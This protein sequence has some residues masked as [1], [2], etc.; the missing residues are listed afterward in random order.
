MPR[1]TKLA[2]WVQSAITDMIRNGAYVQVA[3][4]ACGISESTYY[5]WMNDSRPLYQAFQEAVK[6]AQAEAEVRAVRIIGEAALKNWTAAAW[7]LE[8][9]YPGRWARQE[10]VSVDMSHMTDSELNAAI[11]RLERELNADIPQNPGE[12][13]GRE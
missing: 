5:R 10:R 12:L 4:A 8:R 11:E 6:K 13:Q 3:C 1:N 9:R 2:P 7:W